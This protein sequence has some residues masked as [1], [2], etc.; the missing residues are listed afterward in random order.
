MCCVQTQ[1][2]GILGRN[3]RMGRQGKNIPEERHF[4]SLR[5]DPG[6]RH[7]VLKLRKGT[8]AESQD[9]RGGQHAVSLLARVCGTGTFA[10]RRRRRQRRARPRPLW[11]SQSLLHVVTVDIPH[12]GLCC[13]TGPHARG[14]TTHLQDGSW[15]GP[16]S[17]LL[18]AAPARPP[19]PGPSCV[20]GG[21]LR[22]WVGDHVC[23]SALLSG[24]WGRAGSVQGHSQPRKGL[25]THPSESPKRLWV[26]VCR[27][28]GR[29]VQFR[30][31]GDTQARSFGSGEWRK[32][33]GLQAVISCIQ[34]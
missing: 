23:S 3:P 17:P 31:G 12:L 22:R 27:Q 10:V 18:H 5:G 20:S 21:D 1:L 19:H 8:S 24:A 34:F 30:R 13:P 26:S 16:G 32:A 33:F 29:P 15:V 7:P 2:V 25:K 11:P 14:E 9:R 28:H 4:L 6:R